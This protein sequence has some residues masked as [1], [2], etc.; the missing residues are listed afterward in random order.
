[1]MPYVIAT[2]DTQVS[3]SQ[4][5]SSPK[6]TILASETAVAIKNQ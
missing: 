6:L 2:L 1:M 3:L 4:M 5:Q